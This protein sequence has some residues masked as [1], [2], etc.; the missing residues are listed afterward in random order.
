MSG[1]AYTD[2]GFQ[3]SH[4]I[5]FWEGNICKNI[6]SDSH[7]FATP[8]LEMAAVN[9]I[10]PGSSKSANS[11]SPAAAAASPPKVPWLHNHLKPSGRFTAITMLWLQTSTDQILSPFPSVL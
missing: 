9:A 1:S 6:P 5:L 11:R 3:N 2:F 7:S 8:Q 4:R 10:A